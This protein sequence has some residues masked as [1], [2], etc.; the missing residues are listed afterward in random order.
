MK[1]RL[2]HAPEP[3]RYA[4]F[5]NPV[6]HSRSPGIHAE[7]ARMTGETLEYQSIESPLDG[8]ACCV[9]TFMAGGGR[10]CNVTTPFKL[11]ALAI[12][13]ECRPHAAM[14]GAANCLKFED[15]RI[16][17]ENFDGIGLVNDIRRNLGY[18]IAGRNVLLL[19]AG[20]AVRGAILPFL[21]A[22]PARVAIANRCADE[23]L[24]LKAAFANLGAFEASG[25]D[26]V[27]G[28]PF[29]LVVNATS[30]SLFGQLP[31]IP[32]R[33]F[34]HDTLAYD[35]VYGK[36]L[37]PFMSF[38]LTSGAGRAVDGV[39]MVVEQAAEAFAWWRGVRPETGTVIQSLQ[40]SLPQIG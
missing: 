11:Q 13:D 12:A 33:L 20:G 37:T 23:A 35:L 39:G 30:A 22:R 10:G 4:V 19:G 1:G 2:A 5:G 15:G 3:D 38:A 40:A 16:I 17:A 28:A 36:G 8:F 29:D 27:E 18:E 7:F 34:H 25:F 31:A 9:R 21:E 6:A 24:S 14:A 26:D 32:A